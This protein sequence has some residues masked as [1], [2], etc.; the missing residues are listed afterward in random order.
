MESVNKMYK[1]KI[2]PAV[3]LCGCENGIELVENRVKCGNS[4]K[5]VMKFSVP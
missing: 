5:T 2:L 4:V 3:G 1:I